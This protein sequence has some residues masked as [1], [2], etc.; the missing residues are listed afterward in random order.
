MEL[1]LTAD[2]E[3]FAE[4]TQKFLHDKATPTQLR[5][6]RHDPAGFTAGFWRQGADLGWTSLLVSE[7]DGGGSVSGSGVVDLTL[8]AHEFGRHA[9]P[10]PLLATNVVA[11]ALSRSGS[12]EQKAEVLA[13][14][15]SG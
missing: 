1:A 11:A 4:T 12:A 15:I 10:G 6:L 2:Q 13:R 8:V 14:L 9:A 5:E 3:F 7:A